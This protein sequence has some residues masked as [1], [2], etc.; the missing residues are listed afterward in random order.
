M[1]PDI[2]IIIGISSCLL[3]ENVRYDGQNKY[4]G[5]IVETLGQ[6]V[7]FLPVCPETGIGLGVPRPPVRLLGRNGRVCAVGIDNPDIDITEAITGFGKKQAATL[8]TICGYIFKSRS[9]SCGLN[10]TPIVTD[11]RETCGPGLYTCQIIAAIPLLPVIDEV[12]LKVE[13]SGINFLERACAFNRWQQFLERPVSADRLRMFHVL[14][15]PELERHH[16]DKA[17]E[18]SDSLGSIEDPVPVW[19]AQVYLE[20][21]MSALQ[22]PVITNMQAGE[23]FEKHTLLSAA[24]A[25]HAD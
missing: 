21:F 6:Y 8:K 13:K 11:S 22:T 23:L 10:D 20:R 25:N 1:H 12:S 5:Y 2:P 16:A 7:D 19:A 14:H 18:L 17:K 15:T 24:L 9:P 3:G 4:D